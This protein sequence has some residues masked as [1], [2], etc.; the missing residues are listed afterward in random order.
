MN[1]LVARRRE[2]RDM[3]TSIFPESAWAMHRARNL[4][5]AALDAAGRQKSA[6]PGE[7]VA[8]VRNLPGMGATL[9]AEF[10]RKRSEGKR[11]Q[12]AQIALAHRRINVLHATPRTRRPCPWSSGM[13]GV[14]RLRRLGS[15]SRRIDNEPDSIREFSA[16]HGRAIKSGPASKPFYRRRRHHQTVIA[17]ARRRI[18]LCALL[19]NPHRHNMTAAAR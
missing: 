11:H 15:P 6:V 12:Q 2:P 17:L 8:L 5:C 14:C 18:N 10:Q 7:A 19:R 9:T 13:I 1:L 16:E 3:L 4:A